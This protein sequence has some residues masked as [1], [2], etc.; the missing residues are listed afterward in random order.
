MLLALLV[1]T[2]MA[3]DP[4]SK[5]I[6]DMFAAM[7]LKQMMAESTTKMA[8]AQIQASPQL[9]QIEPEYRAYLKKTMSFDALEPDLRKIYSD[10][11]SEQE[12]KDSTAF[13]KTP[14]GQ[15]MLKK[16]PQVLAQTQVIAQQHI[17]QTLPAFM[18]SVEAKLK[19]SK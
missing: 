5:V 18:K 2:A 7:N 4:N 11:F 10:N 13:Y 16:M 1:S 8:D 19:A 17:R 3:V 6:T 12:L 9:K 14:S 15:S